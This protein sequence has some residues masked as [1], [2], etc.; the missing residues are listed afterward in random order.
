LGQLF[1]RWTEFAPPQIPAQQIAQDRMPKQRFLIAFLVGHGFLSC[2][3][4]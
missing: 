3:F 4:T 1:Q 2:R